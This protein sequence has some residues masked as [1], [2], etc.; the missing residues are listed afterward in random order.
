MKAGKL[1]IYALALI[2]LA[3]CSEY[4]KVLKSTDLNY[5]YEKAVEYYNAEEYN[6][7]YP[8]F[9]ELLTLY[10]GTRKAE[11]VYWY[12]AQ[13]SYELGDYILA[14]YH[15]KNFAK[16]FPN[17]ENA[18]LASFMVGF[19][20]YLESPTYSLDQTYT[21]KAINELQLFVN[22]HPD[23]DKLY[24]SNKLI[25]ELRQKL[26]R[27]SFEIGRQYYETM[28][29]QAAVVAFNNTL[30]D[31]PSTSFREEAMYMRL[32]SAY[33]LARNSIPAKQQQRY[34]EAQTAYFEYIDLYPEGKQANKARSMFERIQTQIQ[35]LEQES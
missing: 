2:T 34:I 18:P 16:T 19:C 33:E 25:D 15:Y 35:L 20:Y 28:Y 5:K 7:A 6:K 13:T 23:H 26:E 31:F 11:D 24:E 22:T 8:I 21:Y 29:Y 4:Q 12:Y 27:K 9:D 1:I 30:N 14:A 17:S 3:S 32:E 10:R